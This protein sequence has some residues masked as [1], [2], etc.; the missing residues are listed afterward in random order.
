[1]KKSR[2]IVLHY[3]T[4]KSIW[5]WWVLLATLYI[6]VV[7]PYYAAV[8]PNPTLVVNGVNIMV[9]ITFLT[10]KYKYILS[11]YQINEY[12]KR[13]EAKWKYGCCFFGEYCCFNRILSWKKMENL[14]HLA[15]IKAIFT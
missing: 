9:E 15:V 7:V 3:S 4:F 11:V 8:S 14:S 12:S 2:F 13:I 5:D 10:G 6:A 1:M